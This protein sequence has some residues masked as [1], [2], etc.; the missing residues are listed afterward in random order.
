MLIGYSWNVLVDAAGQPLPGAREVL[1]WGAQTF[2]L[3]DL[4]GPTIHAATGALRQ[5][6]IKQAAA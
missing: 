2:V 5:P 3:L 1:R 4:A 6:S